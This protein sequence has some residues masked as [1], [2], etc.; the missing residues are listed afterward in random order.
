MKT[1]TNHFFDTPRKGIVI[2]LKG[3]YIALDCKFL[4][5][6]ALHFVYEA[7]FIEIKNSMSMC[8]VN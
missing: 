4:H 1:P 5:K 7:A 3:N 6:V 8:N 2:L